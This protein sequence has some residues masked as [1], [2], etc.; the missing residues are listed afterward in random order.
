MTCYINSECNLHEKDLV[1]SSWLVKAISLGARLAHVRYIK[2]F[3]IC[4][5][6]IILDISLVS[7]ILIVNVW[8]V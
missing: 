3:I 6:F 2:L 7:F 8:L 4:I 5:F 1:E